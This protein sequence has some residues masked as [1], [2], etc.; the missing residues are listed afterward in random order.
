M[1]IPNSARRK[2]SSMLLD[3]A[4]RSR[5]PKSVIGLLGGDNSPLVAG[6]VSYCFSDFLPG[7]CS[8]RSHSRRSISI[9]VWDFVVGYCCGVTTAELVTSSDSKV[10]SLAARW[11]DPRRA[12][13]YGDALVGA[14]SLPRRGA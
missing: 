10:P 1:E 8:C 3:L 11:S 2:V 4:N 7:W 13:T 12:S 14:M 5:R 6:N 9:L